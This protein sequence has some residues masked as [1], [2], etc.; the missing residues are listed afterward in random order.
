M[1]LNFN[2]EG[3]KIL[4]G[5]FDTT[6]KVNLDGKSCFRN[7]KINRSGIRGLAHAFIHW[8]STL[9][10]FQARSSSLREIFVQL[11]RLIGMLLRS[12]S[13]GMLKSLN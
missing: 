12:S 11:D 6:A 10:K 5:S 13:P 9:L 4:T 2:A 8:K 3:D 7:E 1:S